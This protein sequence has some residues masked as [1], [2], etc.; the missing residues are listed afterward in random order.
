MA[1]QPDDLVV[2][3]LGDIQQTQADHSRRFDDIERRL[4]DLDDGVIAALGLA[5]RA[6]VCH[7][8]INNRIDA[9]QARIDRF[10]KKR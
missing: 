2:R 3:I 7:D 1:K 8:A 10:E 4:K 5:T 9:L 6:D